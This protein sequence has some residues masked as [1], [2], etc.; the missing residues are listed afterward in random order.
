VL[1]EHMASETSHGM[2]LPF[3]PVAAPVSF[4]HASPGCVP[5]RKGAS[6]AGAAMIR[7]AL[8]LWQRF[9][10]IVIYW[11]REEKWPARGLM[12]ATIIARG[13]RRVC[14]LVNRAG[15]LL[16]LGERVAAVPVGF[17]MTA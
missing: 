11:F 17:L 10:A 3:S 2:L 5:W 16:A 1:Q 14:A 4:R 6:D 12:C 13:A 9:R 7:F 15:F 8:H